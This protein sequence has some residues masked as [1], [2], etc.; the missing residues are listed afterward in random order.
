MGRAGDR[1]RR[2]ARIVGRSVRVAAKAKL[3]L[4]L[5]VVGKRDDGYHEL[6]SVFVTLDL[7]DD[8]RVA[9]HKRLEVRNTL[10]LDGEDLAARAVTALARATGREPFA[11]VSIRKRIPLAAGM[12][13]GSS[14][15]AATLHGLA[16]VWRVDADL[17]RIGAELGSD[18]PFFASGARAAFVSGRGELVRALAPPR[19]PIDVVVLRPPLRLPTAEVFGSFTMSDRVAASRVEQLVS[20]FEQGRVTPDVIRTYAANDLLAAAERQCEAITT[21]RTAAAARGIP[22]FLTGSGPTLFAVADDRGDAVRMAR[23]LRRAGMRAHPHK[24]CV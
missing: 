24:I 20:A 23:I 4:A 2:A 6:R 11:F 7:A 16:Q 1:A 21:W 22:L 15:A 19:D 17:M 3:N 18:V 10:P 12:G 8:V 9:P 14:D 13:G 5:A